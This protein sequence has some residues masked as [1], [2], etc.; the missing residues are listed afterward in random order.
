MESPKDPRRQFRSLLKGALIQGPRASTFEGEAGSCAKAGQK[1]WQ[2]NEGRPKAS[3]Y[4]IVIVLPST[5]K[6]SRPKERVHRR[7]CARNLNGTGGQRPRIA[8]VFRSE[9]PNST[10]QVHSG[11]DG[12]PRKHPLL[13]LGAP[14]PRPWPRQPRSEG[15]CFAIA[16]IAVGQAGMDPKGGP[17]PKRASR[18]AS[19]FLPARLGKRCHQRP[20]Q[21]PAICA[22]RNRAFL[23][24]EK[25]R[26]PNH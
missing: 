8:C 17:G 11:D 6:N 14:R 13:P 26:N 2:G 21:G 24:F 12:G 9:Q 15:A 7:P 23:F 5:A 10:A 20:G 18:A 4:P 19:V 25:N 3:L 1:I 16:S 22:R